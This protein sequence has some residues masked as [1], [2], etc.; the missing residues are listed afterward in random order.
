MKIFLV[1][2]L[3]FSFKLQAEVKTDVLK[4]PAPAVPI[5]GLVNEVLFELGGEVWTSFDFKQFLKAKNKVPINSEWVK[6]T[7]ND[8]D[9]FIMTRLLLR[10]ITDAM[11]ASEL[12]KYNLVSKYKDLDESL[13]TEIHRLNTIRETDDSR[14]RQLFSKEK[15]EMWMSYMKKKYNFIQP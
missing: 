7:S 1:F 6:L 3:F 10:Q 4:P 14:Y 9:L 11:S 13:S 8:L 12:V 2:I 15:Y 5:I